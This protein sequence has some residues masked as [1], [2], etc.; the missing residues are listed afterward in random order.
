LSFTSDPDA[1][2]PVLEFLFQERF[3]ESVVIELGLTLLLPL[4]IF[5]VPRLRQI[6]PLF[7]LAAVVTV[8]GVFL[9]RWSTV[10]GGQ[11]IPRYTAG[12]LHYTPTAEE[13]LLIASNWGL[14]IFLM[15][16]LTTIVPWSTTED[17][18]AELPTES[19]V[20]GGA[21]S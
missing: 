17:K 7:L 2:A 9:F 6:R 11:E 15:V 19:A 18:N 5:L 20:Q 21:T 1:Y 3:M 12:Y 8:A 14:W 4:V 16:V 10:M 13:I